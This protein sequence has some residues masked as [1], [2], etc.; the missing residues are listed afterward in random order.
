M[1]S[2]RQSVVAMKQNLEDGKVNSFYCIV[3]AEIV[4]DVFAKQKIEKE[5]LNEIVSRNVFRNMLSRDNM[6]VFE[7][8]E[9]KIKNLTTKVGRLVQ[10][11]SVLSA[12][13]SST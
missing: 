6:V 1:K 8:R 9:M 12:P 5:T 2:F 10:D 3:G 13:F 7:D 4:A 11:K